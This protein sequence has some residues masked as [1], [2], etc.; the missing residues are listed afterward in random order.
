MKKSQKILSKE[1]RIVL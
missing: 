1:H